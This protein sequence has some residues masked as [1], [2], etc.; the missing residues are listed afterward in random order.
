MSLYFLVASLEHE[1]AFMRILHTRGRG[2]FLIERTI[3]EGSTGPTTAAYGKLVADGLAWLARRRHRVI[4]GGLRRKGGKGG[5]GDVSRDSAFILMSLFV[6][7]SQEPILHPFLARVNQPSTNCGEHDWWKR[8]L[9]LIS[10]KLHHGR[11]CGQ[12]SANPWLSLRWHRRQ[13]IRFEQ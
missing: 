10:R 12:A 8:L 11:G 4:E 7:S 5:R 13:S 6:L 2:N 1:R 9:G 3:Q